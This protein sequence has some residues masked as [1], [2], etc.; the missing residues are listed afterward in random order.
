VNLLQML[1]ETLLFYHPAVWWLSGQVRAERE[2]CC[3]DVALLVCGDA[4]EYAEALAEIESRRPVNALALA[5]TGGSLLRRIQRMLDASAPHDSRLTHSAAAIALAVVVAAGAAV[6]AQVR[7]AAPVAPAQLAAQAPPSAPVP[8]T[9]PAVPFE[10]PA[11]SDFQTQSSDIIRN[12]AVRGK[13]AMT[14]TDDLTDVRSM[15]DGAYLTLRDRNWL[16]V[17]SLE[18]RGERGTITRRYYVSGFE[19]PWEPEG[20]LWLADR[21]PS[22]IRRSGL[23]VEARTRRILSVSGVDGVLAEIKRV[24]TDYV[25]R[26][27]FQELLEAPPGTIDAQSAVRIVTLAGQ[28]I[29]SDFELRQTL[30][31]AAPLVAPDAA[32][33]KAYVDAAASIA[34]DFERRQAL[35]ALVQ[36]RTLAAG[37]IERGAE[38]AAAM[39]SDFEKRQSLSRMLDAPGASGVDARKAILLAA[40]SIRSD[41]ECATLLLEFTDGHGIEADLANPFFAAVRTINSDFEQGRVLKNLTRRQT[42]RPEIMR[43]A[44]QAVGDMNSDFEQAEVLLSLLRGQPID[45]SARAAFIAAADGIQSDFEQTRVLAALVRAERR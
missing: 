14:F 10:L 31:A 32:G 41:F 34:S 37:A 16:T 44:L 33:V 15:G 24:E 28:V 36:S 5:A 25:R 1:A 42:L 7:P 8:P 43:S 9:P 17:R 39:R 22:L 26:L 40:A 20:R 29:R 38:S 21:L 23:A 45:A 11:D 2:H 12:L 27:Y 30:D 19:Q 4:V 18:L 13:G 3:D 35:D 6:L